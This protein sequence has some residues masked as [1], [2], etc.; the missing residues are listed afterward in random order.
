LLE[1][2][3][4]GLR[5][6][7]FPARAAGPSFVLSIR[8]VSSPK[9]R[10]R[11]QIFRSLGATAPDLAV[12]SEDLKPSTYVP[13]TGTAFTFEYKVRNLGESAAD[14][15]VVSLYDG[16][17]ASGGTLIQTANVSGLN[18]TETR[19]NTIGVTLTGDGAHTLYPWPTPET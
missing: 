6:C 8:T 9:H 10:I 11:Q 19:T 13:T 14:A 18:G 16:D 3:D 4:Y 5:N 15:F 12:F 2:I 1:L 7:F 17:P